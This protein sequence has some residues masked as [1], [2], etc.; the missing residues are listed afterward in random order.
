MAA[1]STSESPT[2]LL[3]EPDWLSSGVTCPSGRLPGKELSLSYSS[4]PTPP[5]PTHGEDNQLSL[6]EEECMPVST[7][8]CSYVPPHCR[9]CRQEPPR[10]SPI[11]WH[12]SQRKG[13]PL[14]T[15]ATNL[16]L[17]TPNLCRLFC[18]QTGHGEPV[19]GL[20]TPHPTHSLQ[21]PLATALCSSL[22]EWMRHCLN[23][24]IHA[25]PWGSAP[26]SSTS[27]TTQNLHLPSTAC[28][29]VPHS[30]HRNTSGKG[31]SA[32]LRGV[33]AFLRARLLGCAW[34]SPPAPGGTTSC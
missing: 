27:P 14:R 9:K 25:R 21:S 17:R 34:P 16:R 28:P 5:L 12:L 20:N 33:L 7:T 4:S 29:A 1:A 18:L 31:F 2:K 32:R 13:P 26:R 6:S 3:S 10:C 15:P 11:S 8:G 30:R 19:P 24:A 22:A 23:S